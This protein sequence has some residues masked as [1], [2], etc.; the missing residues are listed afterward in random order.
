M[1]TINHIIS[2]LQ[3]TARREQY[4]A[5]LHGVL[6][7][8]WLWATLLLV[9]VVAEWLL[10]GSSA[11]RTVLWYAWIVVSA[12]IGGGMMG[13]PVA[14][15][16]GL[17][18]LPS[19]NYIAI[20]VGEAYP[21]VRDTLANAVQLHASPTGSSEL[22]AAAI[23]Q[24]LAIAGQK[25]FSV[26]INKQ[27]ARRWFW[28]MLLAWS[29]LGGALQVPALRSAYERVVQYERSYTPK[30]PYTLSIQASADT[31][32]RGT[33]AWFD[34]TVSGTVPASITLWIREEPSDQFVSFPMPID[35]A[36]TYRYEI[37]AGL[38]TTSVFATG[39]W[40]DLG[41]VSD[42]QTVIVI[43]RP[44]LRS[45]A[46][47][48]TPPAYARSTPTTI[49]EQQADVTALRGSV[50]DL[51]ITSSTALAEGYLE[52]TTELATELTTE[53]S[54]Q[55]IPL[56][57]SGLSGR[58]RFVVQTSGTY[59]IHVVDSNGQSNA[60][61]V[62]YRITALTDAAPT[63][64]LTT[65]ADD[66]D[67]DVS[68][69]LP[70]RVAISDDYGFSGLRLMYRLVQ[71]SYAQ[72][73]TEFQPVAIPL[74]RDVTQ[75]D[76]DYLWHLGR[77]GMTANDRYEFYLE[78]SDN[79]GVSGPKSART[80]TRSVRMPSLE[81]IFAETDDTQKQVQQE[82]REVVKEAE[83]LRKEADALQRELQKQQAQQQRQTDWA[84]RKKAEQLAKRQEELQQRMEQAV[85]KLERMTSTLEKNNAISPE[86]LEKYK[87]LQELLR[88][89]DSPELR[90]MQEQM[91]QAMEQAMEQ[92]SPEELQ[93]MMQ[94]FTFDEEKFRQSIER[95]L[96]LLRRAQAEQKA[97]ELSKR[98]EQLAEQQ[99]S[100]KE[101]TQQANPNDRSRRDQLAQQQ[102]ELQEKTEALQKEADELESLMKE[103]G[104]DMPTSQM[105]A[106]QQELQDQ[107]TAQQMQQAQRD[108]NAGEF[109]K[110]QSPQQKAS[111]QLQRFAQQMRQMQ[112]QM[113]RN[114]NRE[115][116]RSMQRGMQD[117]VSMS[118]QQES[119]MQSMRQMDPSSAQFRQSAQEQQRLQQAMQSVSNSMFQLSQKSTSVSPELAKDLGDALQAM[120][121]SLSQMQ[122]RNSTQAASQQGKAMQAMNSAAQR[123]GQ[124][125]GQMMQGEGGGQGGQ[126]GQG[127]APGQGQGQGPSP[128][129]RLQQLAQQQS[130]INQ[131]S[132]NVGQG[133]GGGSQ[134][135]E[136]QRAE[137]GRLA[138]QQ[139][140]ALKALEELD[141]QTRQMPGSK[142]PLGN[143]RQITEDMREVVSDLQSGSI[144]PETRMRQERILSRLLNASTSMNEREYEQIRES[145]VGQDVERTSPTALDPS[146][147]KGSALQRRLQDL[148]RTYS[149]E[150]QLLIRKY[151]DLLQQQPPKEPA[152]NTPAKR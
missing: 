116:M 75:L 32:L 45:L 14:M 31:V 118:K 100:L 113:R 99:E 34:V 128:F 57:I 59:S 149:R 53:R 69:Q 145:N 114:A 142:K 36:G 137:M 54:N 29:V 108:L 94:Q 106:A 130:G 84:D 119:L 117:M 97:D 71:S 107:Q 146:L 8:M 25:D 2:R 78:V 135:N 22:R 77:L 17:A 80:P 102:K 86:T 93:K 6:T 131:G 28:L 40:Y 89:V 123:M 105:E 103:L 66:A 151:F 104:A 16:L 82:L 129:Q 70:I 98:A 112:K 50:V 127:Q 90:R 63:I 65:P 122:D 9:V 62:A 134:M 115:A 148:E 132:Q 23:E 83:E 92:M 85:E 15:L 74:A 152:S 39:D 95:T 47:T 64:S 150:Y 3:A 12:A 35:S 88:T 111:D 5:V 136:A 1:A 49:T 18:R 60:E 21:D 68:A 52:L 139:G 144:T 43:D 141:Q 42:T 58:G 10:H 140:K 147:L 48:V 26:I 46:G 96:N 143:L 38:T 67:V 37:P 73:D 109:N 51:A 33:P 138:A 27:P 11:V 91:K 56:S 24:G 61:P 13:L 101:Q 41:V 44:I 7:T 110:A 55:R 4:W 76:V 79:D 81:E 125:L 20:R 72:P 126:G 30:A 121:Q 124:A 19:V 133:G 87:E 120:Q